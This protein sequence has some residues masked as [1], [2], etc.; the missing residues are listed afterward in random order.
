[1]RTTRLAFNLEIKLLA[2]RA[3]SALRGTGREI[4]SNDCYAHAIRLGR[5]SSE[6][7]V[8][9]ILFFFQMTIRYKTDGGATVTFLK[10]RPTENKPEQ[11]FLIRR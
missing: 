8:F 1:M 4:Y 10:T 7:R 3:L 6:T 5:C 2:Y 11:P 9:E